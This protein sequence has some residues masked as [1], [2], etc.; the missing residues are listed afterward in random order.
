MRT[1]PVYSD[2]KVTMECVKVEIDRQHYILFTPKTREVIVDEKVVFDNYIEVKIVD[3]TDSTCLIFEAKPYDLAQ[4]IKVIQDLMRQVNNMSTEPEQN[5]NDDGNDL[6]IIYPDDD[7][8]G[9]NYTNKRSN[10]IKRNC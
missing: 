8:C 6:G 9:L 3:E 2:Y 10:V 7:S 1:I 5:E 4:H